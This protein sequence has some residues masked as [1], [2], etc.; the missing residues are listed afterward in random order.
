MESQ[1]SGLDEFGLGKSMDLPNFDLESHAMSVTC[2]I[3]LI[4]L[5]TTHNIFHIAH[6][7]IYITHNVVH[8]VHSYAMGPW[9]HGIDIKTS[10]KLGL[11]IWD[12]N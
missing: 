5:Q 9:N 10:Q 11:N 1:V 7:I 8:I 4:I 2:I 12:F 6:I 3:K